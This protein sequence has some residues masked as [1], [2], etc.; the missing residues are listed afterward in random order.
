MSPDSSSLACVPKVGGNWDL[1]TQRTHASAKGSASLAAA[2]LA[3]VQK[4]FKDLNLAGAEEGR[5]NKVPPYNCLPG[6]AFHSH[7][8]GPTQTPGTR[9]YACKLCVKT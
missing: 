8:L 2:A 6:G 9:P 3:K 7:P 1:S 5:Q 4:G